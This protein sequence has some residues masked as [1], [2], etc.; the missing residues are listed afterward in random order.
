MRLLHEGIRQGKPWAKERGLTYLMNAHRLDFETSGVMLLAK[1]KPVLVALAALFGNNK[2][3]KRYVALVQGNPPEDQFEVDAPIGSHPSRLGEMRVDRRE[4]K[5]SRTR[6]AVVERFAGWS[7]LHCWPITGRTHQIRVHL[8]HIRLPIAGDRLYS[9]RFLMLSQIKKGYRLKGQAVERPLISQT[10]LH[11]EEL[12]FKH[13]ITQ[14]PV[15][16]TAPWP[17]DLTVAVKYLRRYA[18]GTPRSEG[19]DAAEV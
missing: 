11:A 18:T 16:I 8:R 3:E 14:T 13:P 6:F 12:A 1:S 7:L 5:K 15:C 4:G 9:G 10:A 19:L 2:P 17:K